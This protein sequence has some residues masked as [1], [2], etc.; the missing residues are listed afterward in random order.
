MH[1]EDLVRMEVLWT[2]QSRQI[3]TTAS[4][5]DEDQ[6][7]RIYNERVQLLINGNLL[8]SEMESSVF[9]SLVSG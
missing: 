7:K 1:T 5:T 3:T 2:A 4:H 6:Q 9:S 8:D